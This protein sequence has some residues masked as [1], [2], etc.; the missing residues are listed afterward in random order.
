MS[1][2]KLPH[3]VSLLVL[4]GLCMAL[5]SCGG[6]SSSNPPSPTSS[7]PSVNTFSISPDRAV[8][9]AG[10][11][12][13]F[14]A[15]ANRTAHGDLNW[16]VNGVAGGN[17]TLGT[18]SRSGLYKAPP[19]VGSDTLITVAAI[20]ATNPTEAGSVSLTVVPTPA[21]ITVS[22]SPSVAS[23]HPSQAQQFTATVTG[24]ANQGI[25]WFVNGSQGGNSSVG[26]ISATGVYTAP[27]S[28]TA[29]P[30]VTITAESA[31][32][33]ASSATAVV[34]ITAAPASTT[35]GGSAVLLSISPASA[36]VPSAGTQLFTASVTGTS[37]TA[38]SWSISGAGCSGS[39][40]GTI[41]T[42][43][44]S[45]VYLAPTVPPSPA[46]VQVVATSVADPTKSASASM[47]ILPVIVLTV[48]PTSASVPTGTTQQFN[49]SV[50]GTSNTAV[51]WNVAGAGCSGVACGTINSSG[52]Y[53]APAV[54]LSPA[55]VT[56]TATS[57][58]DPTKSGAVNLTIVGSVKNSSV[59]P[60]LPQATVNLTMP[61]QTGTV[62]NIP[63][64]NAIAF[65]NAINSSSCGDTIVL[66]AG[67]TYTGHFTIPNKACTGWTLIESS[68]VSQLTRGT[69][70]G[71]SNTSN[72]ATITT[73]TT[74][75]PAIQF[76]TSAH[77]WRLI[78]L[79]ITTTIGMMQYALIETD[80]SATL[81]SQLPNYIIIDRC[82]V[83]GDLTAQVRRALSFQ[84]A[85]GAVVDSDF[86]EIHQIGTDSQS[87][88]VWNG[89]GPFLIQNN[90]LSA[91]SCSGF[92]TGGADPGIA[93][94]VPSD[95]TIVGNHLWKDYANW[96]GA[97]FD[98]K[99]LEELKNAQRVLIDG[100]V[101][102][103]V[104]GDAQVGN[105]I[106][107]TVRNQSGACTWCV[108]QDV[109]VTHNLVQHAGGGL[110]V[111]G[112]DSD[113]S[114]LPDNR[115]LVQNNV[116]TDINATTWNGSGEA[117][118]ALS[119][120]GVSGQSANNILF[121]HNSFFASN[122]C[123]NLDGLPGK[124]VL[125]QWTNQM[126]DRGTYGLYGS[127]EGAIAFTA[128]MGTT[129][130]ND[131]V[132]LSGT[133]SSTAT[134]PS[135]TF[136]N[137]ISGAGF[138]NYASGNY[139]LTSGSPYHNAGTDGKDIGVWDWT[140][141]TADTANALNGTFSY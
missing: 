22:V 84:V 40:C 141:F 79:E 18:I 6:L 44:S 31:Y 130:Y 9:S 95:I 11:S 20:S 47:T 7:Q 59:L 64:G 26:T 10:N 89:S 119:S 80:V 99:N 66:V 25:G 109:T 3:V 117:V 127:G 139:Q 116:F 132:M 19:A 103:Y 131:D 113:F 54:V 52:L 46:T 129:I 23:L 29:A 106:L 58:A 61:T 12:L 71:P 120:G 112:A 13:Q 115:I 94:L 126:C 5:F 15:T 50:T 21:P 125:F 88:A 140:T 65:Q 38:I 27:L 82:Y 69:R 24:T 81:M 97:G 14:G 105:A 60:T 138:T 98:V 37:S 101:I 92:C 75:T 55:T 90:F 108:V 133:G 30:S 123:L 136:W 121:D 16:M 53:T 91:A 128:Y 33:T 104:W 43:A 72:M 78:G 45:A 57:V 28:A 34:A 35:T 73:N 77:N 87:I 51:G 49:A 134:Y 2:V 4:S 74:G 39:S 124:I 68:Q 122:Y 83:H 70:V 63:A 111:T 85:Y 67:S 42:G 102:E 8:L 56:I 48:T 41:S 96:N 107:F 118:L 62:W 1:C 100:N 17:L 93:N 135:A 86:R 137:T 32:D 76:Q 114:S 110:E 36:S